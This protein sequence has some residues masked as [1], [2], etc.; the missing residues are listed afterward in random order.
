MF[1][2]MRYPTAEQ[3]P[4]S[5]ATFKLFSPKHHTSLWTAYTP[6]ATGW[7]RQQ[8]TVRNPFLCELSRSWLC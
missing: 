3:R 5:I 4:S 6:V 8:T 1:A 7:D 2:A